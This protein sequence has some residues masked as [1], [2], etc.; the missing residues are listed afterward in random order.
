MCSVVGHYVPG[1]LSTSLERWFHGGR[2]LE[3]GMLKLRGMMHVRIW[4]NIVIK[5]ESLA[6][7]I[8][9]V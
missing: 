8:R 1:S 5:L 7:F 2:N 3:A 6:E 4:S 9:S